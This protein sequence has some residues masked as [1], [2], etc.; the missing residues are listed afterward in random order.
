[1]KNIIMVMLCVH[2]LGQPAYALIR[3]YDCSGK[4][5]KGQKIRLTVNEENPISSYRD[6]SFKVN[7]RAVQHFKHVPAYRTNG[8]DVGVNTEGF[9]LW[10]HEPPNMLGNDTIAASYFVGKETNLE[11]RTI[12]TCVEK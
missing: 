2:A 11:K 8:I 7:K 6:V 12:L 5:P 10:I 3:S 1:M 9:M 4:D